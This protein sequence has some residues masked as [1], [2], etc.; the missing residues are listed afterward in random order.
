MTPRP[1]LGVQ[2]EAGN[3]LT[4]DHNHTHPADLLL[5]TGLKEIQLPLISQRPIQ[6][7]MTLKKISCSSMFG[8]GFINNGMN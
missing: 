4:A 5:T 7:Y 8:I 3:D 1:H 2:V 6:W